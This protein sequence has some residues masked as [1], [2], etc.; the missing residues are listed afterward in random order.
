MKTYKLNSKQ[1]IWLEKIVD[2]PYIG[3]NQRSLIHVILANG[4]YLEVDRDRLELIRN[5]YK[6]VSVL[7]S[8]YFEF[9]SEIRINGKFV[10]GLLNKKEEDETTT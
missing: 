6:R 4:F 7:D 2:M 5:E 9:N 1:R 8:S 10:I 3:V